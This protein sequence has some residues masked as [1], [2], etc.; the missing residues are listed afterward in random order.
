MPEELLAEPDAP[1][2]DGGVA[3]AREKAERE[4]VVA[5]LARHHGEIGATARDLQVSRTTMWR[6]MKKHGIES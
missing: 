5:A 1:A 3:A 6:L 2:S 4:M